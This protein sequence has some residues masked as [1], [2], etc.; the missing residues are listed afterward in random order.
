MKKV[1]KR[2]ED[3]INPPL[4]E[5]GDYAVNN[6]TFSYSAEYAFSCLAASSEVLATLIKIVCVT[7]G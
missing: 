5:E 6:M 1:S 4:E 3:K 2:K 7:S